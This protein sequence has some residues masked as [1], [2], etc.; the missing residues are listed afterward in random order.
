M[1]TRTLLNLL[2]VVTAIALALFIYLEPGK[3]PEDIAAKVSDINPETVTSI[4]LTRTQGEPLSFNKRDGRWFITGEREYPADP[5]QLDTVLS[6]ATTDTDRYYPAATLDLA[7]MGLQPPLASVM[8]GET[9][10]DIGSTDPIEH[11]RYVLADNTVHL[12]QDRFQHLLNARYVNFIDRR[13]LPPGSV[14]TG[15]DLPE[16]AM[17]LDEDNHWQMQP[18]NPDT[19]AE[20]IRALVTAWEYARALYVR[21]FDGNSGESIR[22]RLQ[23]I[24]KPQEFILRRQDTNIVLARPELNI[25]YHLTNEQGDSLLELHPKEKNQL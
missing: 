22:V 8:L 19:G 17:R 18:E 10:F 16:L 20:A 24:E 12:V 6:L 15:L 5:F 3:P 25:Q 1:N 13:L 14:V 21:E 23:G 11:R 7:P 2:L 9:S 4:R